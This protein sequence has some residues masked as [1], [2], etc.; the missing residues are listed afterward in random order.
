MADSTR[1]PRR[2]SVR[3]KEF[4]YAQPGAYFVTVCANNRRDVWGKVREG[5]VSL[6]SLGHIIEACWESIPA[7][8]P[9]VRLDQYCVM[10]NHLHGILSFARTGRGTIYRAPT[11][12]LSGTVEVESS[13]K[14]G[15]EQFSQPV[16][17]SLPTVI[18]T[19]KAAVTRNARRTMQVGSIRIWQRGYFDRVI[20]NE[21][22]LERVREYIANNPAK[23]D[24]DTENPA[25]RAK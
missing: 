7:H 18:R 19:F 5:E 22:E 12:A 10:P 25:V 23:W 11:V 1:R 3:L 6:N 24:L 15:K 4:D 8:F 13:I 20:R 9:H 2:R 17:G 14:A 21:R 16:A